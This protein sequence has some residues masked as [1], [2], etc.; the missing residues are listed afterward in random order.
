MELL[1]GQTIKGYAIHDLIGQGAFGVVYRA[2]Q[3]IVDREVAIKV[4]LPQ[5]A[6]QPD[7]VRRFETEAQLVAHLEHLHIVPLYDYWRDPTGAYLVMRYLRGGNL[8]EWLKE[9]PLS[10]EDALRVMEQ[11]ARALDL[12]HR[13]AIIHRDIK[14]TNIL[15]DEERNAFLT[16]FGL[17][18]VMGIESTEDAVRGTPEYISPEQIRGLE[19]GPQADLYSLGLVLYEMLAGNPAF[20]PSNMAEMVD[21]HLK[22][23]VPD[24]T[25]QRDDVPDTINDI[26]HIATAKAPSERYA[27]ALALAR[28]LR[29]ALAAAPNVRIE[30]VAP[31]IEPLTDREL[32]PITVAD[33]NNRTLASSAVRPFLARSFSRIANT[34]R[35]T[36]CHCGICG[37]RSCFRSTIRSCCLNSKS[38][39]S[40]SSSPSRL[41]AST[42]TRNSHTNRTTRNTIVASALCSAPHKKPC[43]FTSLTELVQLL[44]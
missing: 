13:H 37:P 14:P 21:L 1:T 23:P 42:S 33:L 40:F 2:H 26:I 15:L 24:I 12:A 30:A 41:T 31:L 4:I 19:I 6:N 29:E 11:V 44:S 36:F 7:F 43:Q 3:A 18:K 8:R 9:G 17:A 38:S 10:L 27:D 28:T 22:T 20:R 39:S 32:E 16:D 35:G 5:Y 34:V 25:G